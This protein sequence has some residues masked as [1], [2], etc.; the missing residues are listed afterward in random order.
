[1]GDLPAMRRISSVFAVATVLS[2]AFGASSKIDEAIP[3]AGDSLRP[4][5]VR[6]EDQLFRKAGDHEA[7]CKS[8]A[9]HPRSQNRK[10]VAALLR[11]K[12]DGSW[13]QVKGLVAEME[14][15]GSLRARR[16]FWIVNGF[17]CV[18]KP[19]AIRKLAEHEAVSFV[20]L[21]R[22][23]RPV[24]SSQSMST[25]QMTAMKALFELWQK[26]PAE[27][28]LKDAK[29]PWNLE[30]I[31][32][33]E[34]WRKE[35]AF[36]QGVT[37]AVIDSGILP[38]PS[39]AHALRKNPKETF[40]GKDDDGNGLVDDVFGYDFPSGNGFV[41]ETNRMMSHGSVCAGI[42]AGRPSP[43]TRWLTGIAPKAELMLIK[44]SFDLRALEYLLLN[45]ADLVS[46]SF[47]IV[48]R[49]LGHVRGLYRNAFE[50]LSAAGVL[51]LGGAGNFA[52]GPRALARGKQ[53]GLPK[54]IPCVV[55]V[56]GVAKDRSLV[57]FSSRGPCY[58]DKV[59]FFSDYP[60]KKPLGKPDLTAFPT[61]Y[62]MWT[63]APNRLTKARGWREVS[64]E[65]GASLVVGPGGNSFSGPHGVGVAA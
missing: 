2:P 33:P 50:H 4:V 18:A 15:E 54:D 3:L 23:A 34:A 42:I 58:W 16:R 17:S 31:K 27:L 28:K 52:A 6:M 63:H 40:N 26:K 7:F 56:A 21:D 44:G 11:K 20:Y 10:E 19:G 49:E 37:V 29:I 32:A 9:D 12:A 61:G 25:S 62:P 46:M 13:K 1:M 47:M 22:F 55:A 8:H 57:S 60:M 43:K 39:L 48:G 51:A 65:D 14:K 38:A 41:Q 35:K 59:A 64:A 5:F 24:K 36:G 30:G 53:I 45:G